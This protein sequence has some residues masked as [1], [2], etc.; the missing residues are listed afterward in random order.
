MRH[1]FLHL[2]DLHY[3]PGSPE[4]TDV[5]WKAFCADL[6]TQISNY[7][8]PHLVFSGDLVFAAGG[9][10][11][12]YSAFA[13]NIAEG[14]HA[15]FSRDRIICVPGN[16]DISQEALRPSV[17]LQLGALSELTSEALFNDHVPQLS[18]MLFQ[19]KLRDYVA[20]EATFAK[21]GC[22]QTALGGAGWDLANGL[23]VYCLNTALC[24]YA[25][26]PDSHG[27]AI[28]DKSKLMLD[29]RVMQQWLLQTTSTTRILVMHHPIEW[30]APWANSELD[31]IIA[32]EFHLVFSGHIHQ[33]TATFCS[34]GHNG[35]VEVSA[36]PLFTSKSDLLGYSFVTLDT[37]TGGVEVQY[38]QW[39]PGHEFVTGTAL[40]NNDTGVV[41]FPPWTRP[42]LFIEDPKP[43]PTLGDTQAILQAEFDE[44]TTSYSS[45]QILW[46]NRDLASTPE[47]D[48]DRDKAILLA[49][50]DLIDNLRSLVV[51]APRQFGLTCLGRYIALQH[52]R[53]NAN[54]NVVAMLDVGRIPAHRQ[55]MLRFL[56][57]RCQELGVQTAS[58]AAIILD[59]YCGDKPS[60]RILKE[61][62]LA[63]PHVPTIVLQ[64]IDDCARIADA[65]EIDN[66]A[67][68]ETL[69][70]WALTK[71]RLREL[72][73]AYVQEVDDLDDDLVTARVTADIEALNIHRT[74]LNCLMILRLVEQAFEE[75]PVN[76]TE[77]IGRVLTLLFLQFDQI[78]RYA[79]RPDLKDCEYALGYFCEWLVRTE[80]TTFSK[81]EFYAKAI[82]YCKAQLIDLDVEVL[83][84]FLVIENVLVRKGLE[85]GFRF[86]YWLYY[87]AAH[88]MHHD[89]IFSA[90][91]LSDGRY[92]AY[93]ELIEFYAGIDRRRS[94]A[95]ACM[96]T[97][98]A[99][100]NSDFLTRTQI[101]SGLNP[102][103]HATW[104][105]DQAALEQL[106]N[107][108]TNS[109]TES[110]LPAAVKDAVTDKQYDRARP[111]Y[112]E[113][114]RF[115]DTS[116]LRQLMQ[117]IRGAARV[118]RN[119][120]HVTPEAKTA[121]LDEVLSSWV[122]VCQILVILTPV[123]ADQRKATF[124]DI[125]F[126]LADWDE[127]EE[128]RDR[129]AGIMTSILDNVVSWFQD[130]I[131]SKKMGALFCNHIKTHPAELSEVLVLLI[132][133]RQKAPGWE[134]ETRRFILKEHK[135]S[136]Y[137]S[138][139]FAALRTE[140]RLGFF[141]ERT[142]Q[143]LRHLAA[144][145]IAKHQ[146]GVKR[147]N[148]QL[149]R[150]A[151]E[152]LDKEGG[153]S[154]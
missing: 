12:L 132:M 58:L 50:Q 74:P 127:K 120:D 114:A 43:L 28:S 68:F 65:M 55:G 121:L 130:D 19:S 75:S 116:S 56:E 2:S 29:T 59:N 137:L 76:R 31:K 11:N 150:K 48:P 128:P 144:M 139:I 117:A 149:I 147:P 49:P 25:H 7:D 24:S 34:R 47:T 22:C 101:A 54:G 90:F 45:K 13:T 134:R 52:W 26:L 20:A 107:E 77:M 111:Y 69:Y 15:H 57:A 145:T 62:R 143:E 106:Q 3:R 96:T 109:M 71:T 91:I 154:R 79:I 63:F 99:R 125:A 78:P 86:S 97:D 112:Q 88:R 53:Q 92:A 33:A 133:I 64:S 80:R 89:P 14:L 131:F 38:R 115:I 23:G 61:M 81:S 95:V 84:A 83:F 8:D 136:F 17:T 70:L 124:E 42:P 18:A 66:I 85:F 148:T 151:A 152:A 153:A 105:P 142:R 41:I 98:L 32:K 6:A 16:H 129:W 110:A 30:L 40:S 87:F 21:Y 36:P 122:R 72:V 100:M 44:A 108:V 1:T 141:G 10:E 123:L 73:S 39:T 119:S 126:V 9:T 46:V 146:V 113:L 27:A 37:E 5:V 102:F 67:E 93:P 103:E 135:N 82:E 51:R 104:S 118:L 140:F 60:R 4:G 138:R 94:D 35:V